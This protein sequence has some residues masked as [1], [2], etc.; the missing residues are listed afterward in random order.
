MKIAIMSRWNTACGVSLH[1]EL[2]G[3]GFKERGYDV[4]IFAPFAS[5]DWHHRRLNVR[6]EDFVYRC[7]DEDGYINKDI[8]LAENYDVII[9]EGL[10]HLPIEKLRSIFNDIRKK[11]K[12]VAVIHHQDEKEIRALYQLNFDCIVVFDSRYLQEVV[13]KN[14]HKKCYIIPYPFSEGYNV[15]PK[16]YHIFKDK[17]LFFSFGKQPV[18][19]HEIYINVLKNLRKKYDLVYFVIKSYWNLIPRYNWI[20]VEKKTISL[21][22]AYEYLKGADFHLI[23]KSPTRK[24]VVSSTVAATLASLCPTIVPNTRHFEM[25]EDY[26]PVVKFNDEVE[27][28]NKI[29]ELIEEDEIRKGLITNMKKHVKMYSY[30]KIVNQY[31]NLFKKLMYEKTNLERYL[32]RE[33]S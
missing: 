32:T 10:K 29:I 23:P 8:I 1:S 31:I 16:R 25:F 7:Y 19:E 15:N 4:V 24:V 13:P 26:N 30:K 21:K 3:R 9:F 20:Y 28:E 33:S 14:F 11:A 27:L 18:H 22:E 6:D 5:R 12:T 2:I 17:I